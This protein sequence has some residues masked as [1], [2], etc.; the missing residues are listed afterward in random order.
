MICELGARARSLSTLATA[1]T[2]LAR[3]WDLAALG[4]PRYVYASRTEDEPSR[5]TFVFTMWSDGPL[6]LRRMLPRGQSDADGVDPAGLPRPPE[7]QRVLSAHEST[8]PSGVFVY[9]SRATDARELAHT[10][11]AEVERAGW[12]LIATKRGER[13]RVDDAELFAA[14]RDGQQV[15]VLSHASRTSGTTL[16]LLVSRSGG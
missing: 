6:D 3:S 8:R 10:F 13:L 14:E 9:R 4:Q 5:R 1:I 11:R 7:T 2:R 16:T 12:H 15:V